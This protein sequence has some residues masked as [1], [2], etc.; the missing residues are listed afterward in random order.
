MP[1]SFRYLASINT[2]SRADMN[3]FLLPILY[4]AYYVLSIHTTLYPIRRSLT[5]CHNLIIYHF[6]QFSTQA[7][8]SLCR[9]FMTMDRHNSSGQHSNQ[10]TLTIIS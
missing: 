1:C 10:H 2:L 3:T 9:V 4:L 5:I 6:V 8:N 7:D